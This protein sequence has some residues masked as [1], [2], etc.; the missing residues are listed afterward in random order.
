MRLLDRMENID[1]LIVTKLDRLGHNAMNISKVVELFAN[2]ESRLHYL[3]LCDKNN[4]GKRRRQPAMRLPGLLH[5]MWEQTE[6]IH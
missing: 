1:V 4:E 6:I 3:A 5:F 2:F